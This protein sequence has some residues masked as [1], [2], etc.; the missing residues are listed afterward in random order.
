MLFNSN[1]QGFCRNV[2][3]P[4]RKIIRLFMPSV[5]LC[6]LENI[7]LSFTS[8]SDSG[9]RRLSGLTS[10]KSLNLDNRQITDVGISALTS[11]SLNSVHMNLEICIEIPMLSTYIYNDALMHRKLHTNMHITT[12]LCETFKSPLTGV[13][14]M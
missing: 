8:V 5:G 4:M 13:Y 3:L 7:N 14:L 9:L 1:L 2:C 11:K 6:N 10:L 12:Y